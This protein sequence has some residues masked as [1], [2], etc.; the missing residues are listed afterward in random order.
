MVSVAVGSTTSCS[1]TPLSVLMRP[2][3]ACMSGGPSSDFSFD[4][5]TPFAKGTVVYEIEQCGGAPLGHRLVGIRLLSLLRPRGVQGVR[6]DSGP[7]RCSLCRHADVLPVALQ[8]PAFA[9]VG[10]GLCGT[11]RRPHRGHRNGIGRQARRLGIRR[12]AEG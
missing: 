6:C 10:D 8:P 4:L 5:S 1:T 7:L 12:G 2:L 9:K 11:E 3:L